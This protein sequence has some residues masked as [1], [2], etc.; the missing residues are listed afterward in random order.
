MTVP[1]PKAALAAVLM[2]MLVP[3]AAAQEPSTRAEEI[4]TRQAE[5]AGKTEPYRRN[6]F[7]QKMLSIEEAGGFNV[8]RGFFVSFGDIKSGSSIAL[9]PAYGKIF[10]NGSMVIAKG[11]YS[12]RSFK[13]L[14]VSAQ[15]APLAGGR[16]LFSGRARWQ[17]AP[18]LAL[19][20]IGHASPKDRTNYG[21]TKTELS[22]AMA[23]RPVRLLRFGAGAAFERYDTEPAERPLVGNVLFTP[24]SHP[25]LG[26]DADYAHS[27]VMAAI[28]SR[29][30]LTYS[31][32][33]S[34]LQATL[35]DYRQRDDGPFTF[36]RVDG[37]AQQLIPILH[38]N[39]VIDLSLR[40]ST[41][42]TK[43]GNEVPFFLMPD[44]G[45]SAELRGFSNY[46]FRDRHSILFT[47]EYRW[48]VQE[49][50]DMALFYDAGKVAARRS[51]LDFENLK[52]NFGIGLRF[53]TPR[54]TALRLEVAR[55]NE[56]LR[57]IFAF[58][59]LVK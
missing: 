35:H 28:D 58:G 9:G 34:L 47:A 3:A 37:V 16:A 51:D 32:S 23:L 13:L 26:A 4:A 2:L 7:E 55:S 6:W 40:A 5:K 33:G 18:T 19:Y 14:Q 50:V 15:S 10:G 12:I 22:A 49:Y 43:D 52:S 25:A 54:A 29:D 53:H 59:G 41:T 45:G 36:Q 56:G 57:L 8:Q 1:M 24:I 48:Y 21:E 38:G 44:L 27:F 11:A 42:S 39:W 31:R 17:D 46:R 20:S 30:G